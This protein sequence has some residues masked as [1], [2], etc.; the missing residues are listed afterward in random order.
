MAFKLNLPPNEVVILKEAEVAHGGVMANYTD[1]L[2]L[3]NVNVICVHRGIFQNVKNVFYYPLNQLKQY[4]G[5][6]QAIFGKVSNG[7]ACLELYFA[8][9][10]ESFRFVSHNKK[11]IAQWISSISETLGCGNVTIS[12]DDLDDDEEDEDEH[13]SGD[14]SDSIAGAF[15][16]VA[17]EFCAVLGLK[18]KKKSSNNDKTSEPT[19]VNKKCISCSAPLIGK[20]GQIV[21]CKYCDTDQTL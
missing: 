11:T 5:H 8:N 14:D 18:D 10:V 19:T 2:I 20:K 13:D 21:H 7:D 15:K 12:Y 3:T 4:N 6:V 1:D 17:G 16:E 9:G